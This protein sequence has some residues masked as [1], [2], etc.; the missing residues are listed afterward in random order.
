MT[1][2][3]DPDHSASEEVDWSVSTLSVKAGHISMARINI[4]DTVPNR[5]VL[6]LELILFYFLLMSK[7]C[8]ICKFTCWKIVKKHLDWV[9]LCFTWVVQCFTEFLFTLYRQVFAL[10]SC[11]HPS[12]LKSLSAAIHVHTVNVL[13]FQTLYSVL[14][15]PKFCFLCNYFL[16]HLA[17]SSYHNQILD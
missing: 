4:W 14:I 3:V 9:V 12:K 1:N 15:W 7:H 8:Y 6:K 17:D 13:K 5:C 2:N 10:K 11:L 16:K